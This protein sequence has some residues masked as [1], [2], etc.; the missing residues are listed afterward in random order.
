MK[1]LWKAWDEDAEGSC[2]VTSSPYYFKEWPGCGCALA[3]LEWQVY[4]KLIRDKE[5]CALI[6]MAGEQ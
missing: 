3:R 6:E 5:F 4:K 2:Q 1:E